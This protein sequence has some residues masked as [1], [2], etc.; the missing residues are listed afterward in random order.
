MVHIHELRVSGWDAGLVRDWQVGL[1]SAYLDSSTRRA[2]RAS[3]ILAFARTHRSV[4]PEMPDSR[5]GSIIPFLWRRRF[6]AKPRRSVGA[7]PGIH[8]LRAGRFVARY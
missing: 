2:A 5:T 4:H 1:V 3:Q 7:F 8:Q 6:E